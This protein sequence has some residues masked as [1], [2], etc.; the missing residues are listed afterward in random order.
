MQLSFQDT[1]HRISRIIAGVLIAAGIIMI[2][3]YAIEGS[4]GPLH[5]LQQ[6]MHAVMAPVETVG[7]GIGAA[8]DAAEE[9]V[10]DATADEA[11]LTAL[12]DRNA[13]L[14]QLLTQAEE[15][16][17]ESE[18]LRELLELK[19]IYK[20]EGVSARV[21]GRSTDAWNQTITLDVGEEDGVTPGLTVMGPAGVIGQVMEASPSSCLVRLLTDP[22]SGVAA[23]VQS[24]RVE[25]I[26]RGSLTGAL[27]LENVSAD[28]EVVQGDVVLTSGLGGS[29]TK[30]LLIGTVVR[31]E[32]NAKDGT[33]VIVVA[34]NQDVSSLEEVTVVFSASE[35][36]RIIR[37]DMLDGG[38][39]DATQADGGSQDGGGSSDGA[40]AGTDAQ[41]GEDA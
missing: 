25:G 16:R 15:Y 23:Q 36:A 39:S 33:R 8:A 20:L 4:S 1:D 34:P 17:L 11:T 18:R 22:N 7:S 29:F 27:E 14:T 13:E 3:V 28:A 40:D 38:A 5:R 37:K 31:V 6:G 26:V 19:D 32:G 12:R 30:G 9:A 24:S 10:A 41:G 2:A 21:I 35:S